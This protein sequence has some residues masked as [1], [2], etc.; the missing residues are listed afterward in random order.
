MGA[1]TTTPLQKY[2][3][4]RTHALAFDHLSF[5]FMGPVL[6]VAGKPGKGSPKA[7][8]AGYGSEAAFQRIRRN[9]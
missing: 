9:H 3:A 2:V 7:G 6:A 4:E 8:S 5:D 1:L